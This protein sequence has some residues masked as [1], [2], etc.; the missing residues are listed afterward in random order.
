MGTILS[1][2][3]E[4]SISPIEMLIQDLWDTV[5]SSLTF[6]DNDTGF[7]EDLR[8]EL[9]KDDGSHYES[10]RLDGVV[11]K[12]FENHSL[13]IINQ[14]IYMDLSVPLPG[15]KKIRL[16]DLVVVN[17]RRKSDCDAWRVASV[18]LVDRFKGTS[19]S[20]GNCND[21]FEDALD[22][23]QAN[24]TSLTSTE[25]YL[26][27][28]TLVGQIRSINNQKYKINDESTEFEIGDTNG[29]SYQVGDWLSMKVLYDP[30]E[31]QQKPKCISVEPLRKWKFEGRI[32]LL[33][34]KKGEGVVDND[35]FFQTSVC[36]NG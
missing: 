7:T 5:S 12:L 10:K 23:P 31:N 11:T 36:S 30:E 17:V 14:E 25:D 2:Q 35:I 29:I 32:N 22:E 26:K 27:S 15:G 16:G 13:A 28:K 4:L 18:D 3:L 34:T 8:E 33:D 9:F 21:N 19:N 1:R 20:W 24:S 6:F